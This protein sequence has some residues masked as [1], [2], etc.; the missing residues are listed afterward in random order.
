M[1]FAIPLLVLKGWGAGVVAEVCNLLAAIFMIGAAV[2]AIAM[3]LSEP[4]FVN[5]LAAL[6]SAIGALGG[7][8]WIVA[9]T[10]AVRQRL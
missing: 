8:A 4:T 6:G 10:I 7:V 1:N 2:G 3:Y 5:Q 9:A